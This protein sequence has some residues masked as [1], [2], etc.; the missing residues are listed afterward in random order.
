MWRGGLGGGAKSMIFHFFQNL[1]FLGHG[2]TLFIIFVVLFGTLVLKLIFYQEKYVDTLRNRAPAHH[3]CVPTQ[4]LLNTSCLLYYTV[5]VIYSNHL[6]KSHWVGTRL[7]WAGARFPGR[8]HG[9]IRR[10]RGFGVCL[11]I[12]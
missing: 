8:R 9:S 5:L 10:M 12:S 1:N 7:W 11:H 6:L 3:N 2:F 4:W